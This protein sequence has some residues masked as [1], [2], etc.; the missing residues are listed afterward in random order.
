MKKKIKL[1]SLK[2]ESFLTDDENSLYNTIKGG[3]FTLN[4]TLSYAPYCDTLELCLKSRF[5]QCGSDVP[6]SLCICTY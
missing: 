5:N 4:C 2:V 1:N 3:M 6:Q